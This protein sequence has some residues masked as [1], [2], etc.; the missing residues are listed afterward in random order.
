[1]FLLPCHLEFSIWLGGNVFFF[2]RHLVDDVGQ[3]LPSDWESAFFN[4]MQ[5]ALISYFTGKRGILLI[6]KN[7]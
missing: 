3:I 2:G 6:P 1:M 4:K 5:C 7:C